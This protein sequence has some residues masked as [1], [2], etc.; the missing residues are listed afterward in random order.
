M[1]FTAVWNAIVLGVIEGVTEFLPVSSTGHMLLAEHF[2]GFKS[3]SD[4]FEIVIQLGAILAVV[5][6]Y[7]GRLWRVAVALPTRIEARYFVF[8]V[9]AA[10]APVVVLGSLLHKFI[11]EV[12]F[13]SPTLIAV[14]LV[15][16]GVIILLVERLPKREIMTDSERLPVRTAVGIGLFQCL[17]MVPGVSRSG[18]TIIGG[19][20]LGVSRRAA[21]EFS[22]FLSIPT[23][24][25]ASAFD[26]YKNYAGL[27]QHD[28]LLILIGFVVAFVSALVVVRG[29]IDFISRHGLTPFAWY[30]IAVG[31]VTLAALA[32]GW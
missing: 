6:L 22:F 29:F 2:L 32:A 25:A 3:R 27:D 13:G 12:L 11:K 26:L 17:A 23:M 15:V 21:A 4:V 10:F 20:L 14:M 7:F 8:T 30:R 5:V 9:V 16:G 19:I 31:S 1:D 24:F 18:A 28:W